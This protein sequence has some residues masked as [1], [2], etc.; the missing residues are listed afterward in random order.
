[1]RTKR[2]LCALA[3]AVMILTTFS[4]AGTTSFAAG[5]LSSNWEYLPLTN[6]KGLDAA[7]RSFPVN[8]TFSVGDD[9]TFFIGSPTWTGNGVTTT[10]KLPFENGATVSTVIIPGEM[11]YES[12]AGHGLAE[13]YQNAAVSIST[14]KPQS[15]ANGYT[16]KLFYDNGVSVKMIVNSSNVIDYYVAQNGAAVG[17]SPT[18]FTTAKNSEVTITFERVG[19]TIRVKASENGGAA[20][21]LATVTSNVA[22][23]NDGCYLAF[24]TDSYGSA[25]VPGMTVKTVNG[26]APNA[27]NGFVA[28]PEV[29][30]LTPVNVDNVANAGRVYT[31]GNSVV[32][33]NNVSAWWPMAGFAMPEKVTLDGLSVKMKVTKGGEETPNEYV[34]V[35]VSAD[36]PTAM[37]TSFFVR[38]YGPDISAASGFGVTFYGTGKFLNI[39]TGGVT[40]LTTVD[41]V[42]ENSSFT[43]SYRKSGDLYNVLID[44]AVLTDEASG[45]PVAIDM[46]DV[47]DSDGKVYLSFAG[48]GY[49]SAAGAVGTVSEING[50]TMDKVSASRQGRVIGAQIRTEG[51]QGLRFLCEVYRDENYSLITEYGFLILPRDLLDKPEDLVITSNGK[52]VSAA[53]PDGVDYLR[54]VGQKLY[55]V[56]SDRIQFTGVLIGIPQNRLGRAFTAVGYVTYQNGETV[57]TNTLSRSVD[58]IETVLNG[59]PTHYNVPSADSVA[60]LVTAESIGVKTTNSG[61]ANS[62]AIRSYF[63][64]SVP[65]T[66]VALLFGEGGDYTFTGNAAITFPANVSLIFENGSKL[67]FS[68]MNTDVLFHT[69]NIVV[70]KNT[71]IISCGSAADFNVFFDG[72]GTV[73]AA[74][75]GALTGDTVDDSEAIMAAYKFGGGAVRFESGDYY[76]KS[77][78][79]IDTDSLDSGV[80][81]AVFM[82]ESGTRFVRPSDATASV[83]F[84]INDAA[85]GGLNAYFSDIVFYSEANK[86]GTAVS[87]K[88]KHNAFSR[89]DCVNCEFHDFAT[90]TYFDYSGGCTFVNCEYYY[91]DIG[92]D[93]GEYSMFIYYDGCYGENCETFINCIVGPSG[94]VSNG[95][96]VTGCRSEDCSRSVY[97]CENQAVYVVNCVFNECRST[98]VTLYKC[99]DSRVDGNTISTSAPT[100][101]I[102]GVSM[103]NSYGRE[104]VTNNNI[105]GFY[106]GIRITMSSNTLVVMGNTVTDYRN[107]GVYAS[108]SD[109]K[110]FRNTVTGAASA[111]A[112]P[113]GSASRSNTLICQN[114]FDCTYYNISG[115][116]IIGNNTF[117]DGVH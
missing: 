58:Y 107:C 40:E 105:S 111:S 57:Y 62:T 61:A 113:I 60:N 49:G 109:V 48:C 108:G 67:N 69:K 76:V 116:G 78:V 42:L 75:F 104:S 35:F 41:T 84:T 37:S 110:I 52:I 8:G 14:D 95:I 115:S 17:S 93:N 81:P 10:K 30:G 1:M 98:A 23:F 5:T 18:G 100:G 112:R 31:T 56:F 11:T 12:T 53:A 68:D 7:S 66:G 86:V 65:S 88:G 32:I 28:A 39:M 22:L 6:A 13:P 114:V 70:D 99:C 21:V 45:Q 50:F 36:K 83:M 33:D 2:I 63:N 15:C 106:Q 24:S 59:A 29:D 92:A 46:S 102:Y 43:L 97:I 80:K 101:T 117:A 34:G 79:V 72:I 91:C 82:G 25:Y 85:S 103:Q 55:R 71:Q 90:G 89:L 3:A 54:I 20:V 19:A 16:S 87:Y 74:W 26:T 4:F 94:G 9:G 96:M 38:T 73:D 64:S 27:F 77:G 51:V 47:V 44:G